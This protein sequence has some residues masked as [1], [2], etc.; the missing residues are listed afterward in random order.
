MILSAVDIGSNAS[1]LL[2]VELSE[3]PAGGFT[4]KKI[5]FLRIPTQ[6]GLDVFK[7]KKISAKREGYLLHTLSIFKD[8]SELYGSEAMGLVATSALREAKNGQEIVRK[9]KSEL[10]LNID[11]IDGKREAELVAKSYR[12]VNLEIKKNDCYVFL[13]VGGGS[14][15]MAVTQGEKI[16]ESMSFKVGAIKLSGAGYSKKEWDRFENYL[17]Y[18]RANYDNINLVASGGNARKLLKIFGVHSQR[19]LQTSDLLEADKILQQLSADEII[20]RYNV[21]KDRAVVMGGATT[22]FKT[23]S[24]TLVVKQIIIPKIGLA[25]GVIYEMA[26]G[27]LCR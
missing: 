7:R 22:I 3:T 25:D 19:T 4:H 12:M 9:I 18:L 2:I 10:G 15:D 5:N 17:Q 20:R 6:L 1:R 11:V 16:L 24:K 27:K 8:L 23:A 13:D 21:K 14:S 26:Q